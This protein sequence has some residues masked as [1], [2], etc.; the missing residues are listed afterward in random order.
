MG[1]GLGLGVWMGYCAHT[2]GIREVGRIL[3]HGLV[4]HRLSRIAMVTQPRFWHSDVTPWPPRDLLSAYLNQL[5]GSPSKICNPIHIISLS[6]TYHHTQIEM[7]EVQD[8]QLIEGV[9]YLLDNNPIINPT[10]NSPVRPRSL[11]VIDILMKGNINSPPSRIIRVQP[12]LDKSKADL[13]SD[14][15]TC[16]N[17]L[18]N[19]SN[20]GI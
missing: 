16:W 11:R 17:P 20:T 15:T 14:R 10:F 3:D 18:P 7:S 8:G 19:S 6:L 1:R 5:K 2:F 4:T 12:L 9:L 13:S